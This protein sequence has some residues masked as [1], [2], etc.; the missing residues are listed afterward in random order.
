M[1]QLTF[2]I[3]FKASKPLQQG[4]AQNGGLHDGK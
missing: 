3:V 4:R 2:H 1:I